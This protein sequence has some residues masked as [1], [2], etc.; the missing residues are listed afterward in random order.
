MKKTLAAALAVTACAL[1]APVFAQAELPSFAP[2]IKKAAPAVVNIGVKGKGETADE[3][4]ATDQM[5]R[6][7]TTPLGKQ[8][9]SGLPEA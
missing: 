4:G 2:V 6:Q 9:S 1:S 7:A 8:G 5:R 3:S